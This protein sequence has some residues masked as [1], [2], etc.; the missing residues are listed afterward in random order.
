MRCIRRGDD[1]FC[2]VQY[3]NNIRYKVIF[4][5]FVCIIS[6]PIRPK[7]HY[8]CIIVK[9]AYIDSFNRFYSMMKMSVSKM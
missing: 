2:H 1:M 9:C 8:L 4:N 7:R 5:G 3:D 6:L